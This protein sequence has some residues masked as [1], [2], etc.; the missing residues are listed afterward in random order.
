MSGTP[1]ER[2]AAVFTEVGAISPEDA[3]R[4]VRVMGYVVDAHSQAGFVLG[5]ETGS[6]SVAVDTLPKLQAFVRVIG[7]VAVS[8]DG[9]ATIRAEVVQDLAALDKQ[10]F[11]RAMKLVEA[12]PGGRQS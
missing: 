10:L 12:A 7:S 4:R 11:K 8:S 6:I 9:G 3:G 5:D 2:T 1:V